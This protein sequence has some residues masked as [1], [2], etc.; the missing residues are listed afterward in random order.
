MRI[1]IQIFFSLSLLTT[2]NGQNY[3]VYHTGSNRDTITAS[4]GGICMMGGSTEDDNAMRWFLQRAGGGD[5][6]VLRTSGSNG[7]NSYMYS[8]LGVKVNSVETIVCHNAAASNE[9][10]IHEKIQGLRRY[11]LLERSG[12]YVRYWQNTKIDSL[13]ND[14][15]PH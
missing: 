2:V 5:I 11:G 14:G 3:T 15:Y 4:E 9:A 1:F 10:Y 13:I 8:K 7:Y 12:E 6:L